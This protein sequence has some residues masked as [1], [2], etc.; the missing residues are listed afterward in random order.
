M[1][2][3]RRKVKRKNK[4]A[5]SNS[6]SLSSSVE[7][8]DAF[9][10]EDIEKINNELSLQESN[11]T[12]KKLDKLGVESNYSEQDKI[13]AACLFG[14]QLNTESV[15]GLNTD[16]AYLYVLAHARKDWVKSIEHT[17]IESEGKDFAAIVV[18][19]ED[20][21]L[22]TI[23]RMLDNY[24]LRMPE[25]KFKE[26]LLADLEGWIEAFQY[27]IFKENPTVI[28][29]LTAGIDLNTSKI[30]LEAHDFAHIK[31]RR[32]ELDEEKE[33]RNTNK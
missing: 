31:K 14:D 7:V 23:N 30:N 13:E 10:L 15:Q 19:G 25:G 33:K 2:K 27:V 5:N 28:P 26:K 1:G 9:E 4:N 16:I 24:A 20:L 12:I 11:R 32:D 18:D 17:I 22:T 8:E 29:F 6:N 21:E 3:G